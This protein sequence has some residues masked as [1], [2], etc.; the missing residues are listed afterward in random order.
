MSWRRAVTSSS[1]SKSWRGGGPLRGTRVSDRPGAL[2]DGQLMQG[3]WKGTKH[4]VPHRA[5]RLERVAGTTASR[6]SKPL[7]FFLRETPRFQHHTNG[8]PAGS[9]TMF[10][11]FLA[12]QGLPSQRAA[13]QLPSPEQCRRPHL[14]ACLRLR[15]RPP[16]AASRGRKVPPNDLDVTCG[17]LYIYSIGV[18]LHLLRN[19]S[20]TSSAKGPKDN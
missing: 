14:A 16:L 15:S 18:M 7:R 1:L 20:F 8:R 19:A 17:L 3:D 12:M 11:T 9:S 6:S 5:G 10:W 4:V 13:V 2:C